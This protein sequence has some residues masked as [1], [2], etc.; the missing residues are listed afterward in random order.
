MSHIENKWSWIAERLVCP[1]SPAN[2]IDEVWHEL[3]EAWNQLPVS[4]IQAKF[5][6]MP[7]RVQAVLA[8]RVVSCFY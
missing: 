2:T 1:S 6:L 8:Y 7:N 5:D 4:V 3:E